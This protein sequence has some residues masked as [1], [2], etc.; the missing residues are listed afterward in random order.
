MK[1]WLLAGFLFCT[2]LFLSPYTLAAT[3][4]TFAS[5]MGGSNLVQL[6][7]GEI[8]LLTATYAGTAQQGTFPNALIFETNIAP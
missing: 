2:P 3:I 6:V 5:Q 7:H 1:R 8:P 4:N